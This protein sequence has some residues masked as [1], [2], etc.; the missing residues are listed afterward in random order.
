MLQVIDDPAVETRMQ[1]DGFDDRLIF[2][3]AD[4]TG[5]ALEVMAV[6]LAGGTLL[7]IHAMDLRPKWR[8]VYDEDSR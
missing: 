6:E 8:T 7:V 5:R 1:L 4:A 2:L 3:G